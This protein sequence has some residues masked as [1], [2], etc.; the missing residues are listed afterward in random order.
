MFIWFRKRDNVRDGGTRGGR[1]RNRPALEC[2]ERR[3]LL[4]GTQPYLLSGDRWSNATPITYSIAAD[5]V[6][7]D[8]KVNNLNAALDARFGRDAWQAEIDRALQTWA[9]VA[10]IDFVRVADSP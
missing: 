9:S 6:T 2:L 5:G 1:S 10:D 7:W 8:R 4:A 3:E